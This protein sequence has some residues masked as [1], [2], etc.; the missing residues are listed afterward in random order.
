MI[1]E[2]IQTTQTFLRTQSQKNDNIQVY[3]SR[4]EILMQP[5]FD[6]IKIKNN[7]DMPRQVNTIQVQINPNN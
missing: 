1:P 2:T 3:E 6:I 7:A 5:S 4:D